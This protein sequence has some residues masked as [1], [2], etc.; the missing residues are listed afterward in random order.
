MKLA[1]ST[2]DRPTSPAALTCSICPFAR[3]L[4]GN[5]YVCTVS[6]TAADVVRGHWESK[7]SCH[8]AIAQA[9]AEKAA[10][11]PIAQTEAPAPATPKS[12]TP[13]TTAPATLSGEKPAPAPTP[14]AIGENDDSPPNRGDNGR[15]RVQP[16]AAKKLLPL[17]VPI[18]R[19]RSDIPASNFDPN[20]LEIL[21]ELMLSI[22]GFVVPPVL[23][24]DSGGYRVVSGHLQFHAAVLAKQLNPR[25][26]ETIPAIVLEPENQAT[27]LAQLKRLKFAA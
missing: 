26:G 17:I 4:D 2:I 22:G 13:S 11:A 15:G 18:S 20:E 23:V 7:A 9:E 14:A 6:E 5:R 10:Q 12:A 24:R 25:A 3:H 19:I 16:I 27:A 21:G 8:E 1:Q